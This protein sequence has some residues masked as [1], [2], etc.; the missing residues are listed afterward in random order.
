MSEATGHPRRYAVLDILYEL[1]KKEL[2]VRYKNTYLGYLWSLLN[3]LA[4]ALVL[5]FAFKLV[6][7]IPIENYALFVVTALFPWQWFSNSVTAATLVFITNGALIRKTAF[8]RELLVYSVVLNDGVHFMLSIPVIAVLVYAYGQVPSVGWLLWL[9]PLLVCQ[10]VFVS[11]I[12]LVVA[13]LNLFFRDLER[14][15]FLAINL[16]FYLT[17][18]LYSESLIPVEYRIFVSVNPLTPLVQAY[19]GLFLEQAPQPGHVVGLAINALVVFGL[20]YLVFWRLRWRFAE[21][22]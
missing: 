3:P 6:M 10:A 21:V 19:R 11:G 20:G 22:V 15:I 17:P 12:A 5:V 18:V 1:T 9:P 16:L 7:R 13:S 4:F 2:K 8:P 14:L